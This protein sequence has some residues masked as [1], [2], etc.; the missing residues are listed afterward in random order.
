MNFET[1]HEVH[2]GVF[3]TKISFTEFG[4]DTMDAEHEE[5]L[6]EDFGYPEVN[7]GTLNFKG[8]FKKSDDLR[9]VPATDSSDGEEVSFIMNTKHLQVGPGFQAI[10]S[11]DSADV[12]AS[13]IDGKTILDT[14]KLIAEA[15]CILFDTVVKKAITDVITAVKEEKTRFETAEVASL[16][17]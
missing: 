4:S 8:F 13:E 10:Y 9:I 6:F 3:S 14:K 12:P 15:K 2:N 5:A 11:C 17:V 16:R 7:L 1:S